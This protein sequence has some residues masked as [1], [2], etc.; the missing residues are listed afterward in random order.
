MQ[1]E[2][3]KLVHKIQ[4]EF[5][6]LFDEGKKPII[7]GLIDIE[8]YLASKLK[9]LFAVHEVKHVPISS[10]FSNL[11]IDLQSTLLTKYQSYDEFTLKNIEYNN[12]LYQGL[13]LT[14]DMLDE[15]YPPFSI[16]N[17]GVVFMNKMPQHEEHYTNKINNTYFEKYNHLILE[18]LT[19]YQPQFVIC[20]ADLIKHLCSDFEKLEPLTFEKVHFISS[21]N[22]KNQNRYYLGLNRISIKSFRMFRE[23]VVRVI[24][25]L[26]AS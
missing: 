24:I 4:Q 7:D 10:G 20:T 16:D 13:K 26:F 23:E 18:Q 9:I 22:D 15:F 12:E 11:E 1:E 5:L 2:H 25:R 14:A 8:S 19:L 17:L 6:P 21:F 3:N